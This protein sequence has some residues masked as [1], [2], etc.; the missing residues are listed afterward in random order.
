[1][2][3]IPAG[4]IFMDTNTK[5]KRVISIFI[6]YKFENGEYF[7]YLQRRSRDAKSLPGYF[8]FWGGGSEGE[9]TPEETLIRE[10]KEELDYKIKDYIFFSRYE[11]FGSIKSIFYIKVD[12]DFEKNIKI[13]EGDY[14]LWFSLTDISVEE[15]FIDE[16]KLVLNNLECFLKGKNMWIK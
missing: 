16:D 4:A 13:G 1:M 10:I 12:T 8:G 14:G 6:P 15:C 3:D 5:N 2:V 11:F 9:E 7:F